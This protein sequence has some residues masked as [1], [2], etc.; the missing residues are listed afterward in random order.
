MNLRNIIDFNH[1]DCTWTWVDINWIRCDQIRPPGFLLSTIIVDFVT[2]WSISTHSVRDYKIIEL[3][4]IVR[5]YK[6]FLIYCH[7]SLMYVFF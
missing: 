7:A 2:L 1:W 4:K 5:D 3:F 6:S